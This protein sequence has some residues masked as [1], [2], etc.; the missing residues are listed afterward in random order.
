MS[1]CS[2]TSAIGILSVTLCFSQANAGPIAYNSILSNGI[3]VAGANT[4]PNDSPSDPVG[5]E[6]YAF[7]ATAGDNIDISGIRLVGEYDMTFWVFNGLYADTTDFIGGSL[8][9]GGASFSLLGDDQDPP[10][11]AG[12]YGDPHVSF[13]APYSGAYTVA[14]TNFLSSGDPPYAFELT[15]T[16]S[17]AAPV[18]E[19][20]TLALFSL[21]GIG[22]AYRAICRR[23][24]R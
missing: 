7:F 9:G 20:S 2:L 12:P 16:G 6:Y 8:P 17:T 22:L 3:T 15:M 23:P 19:P 14:V 10:N 13:S 5:A 24:R 18:P 11:I 21:G 1:K 4:Q